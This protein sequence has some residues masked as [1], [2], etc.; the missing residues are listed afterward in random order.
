MSKIENIQL[1]NEDEEWARSVEK[2][3]QNFGHIANVAGL[4][5]ILLEPLTINDGDWVDPNNV[6]TYEDLNT[7]N[8]QLQDPNGDAIAV[9]AR[10]PVMV[11]PQESK[12]VTYTDV[13]FL[14]FL[15]YTPQNVTMNQ[16]IARCGIELVDH[17]SFDKLWDVP[18]S[19][20][21]QMWLLIRAVNNKPSVDVTFN[22]ALY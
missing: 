6:K 9:R 8:K 20:K 18:G 17:T 7:P 5:Y 2:I 13:K 16:E 19:D 10:V 12:H 4:T 11:P 1:I 15:E 14:P 3:N 22:V 21:K